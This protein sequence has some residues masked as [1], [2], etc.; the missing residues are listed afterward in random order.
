VEVVASG[1]PRAGFELALPSDNGRR[2]SV[3]RIVKGPAVV[4]FESLAIA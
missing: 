1:V 2:L 3:H 4:Q